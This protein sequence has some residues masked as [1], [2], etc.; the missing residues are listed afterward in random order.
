MLMCNFTLYAFNWLYY[1]FYQIIIIIIINLTPLMKHRYSILRESAT[2]FTLFIPCTV[3]QLSL[4]IPCTAIQLSLFIPCTVIQLSLF[5]PCTVI[6][7]SLFIPCTVIQISQLKPTKC[8]LIHVHIFTMVLPP[9][10]SQGLQ[11]ME[12]SWSH[13]DT[14]YSV[15][16]IWTSD[17]P[18]TETSTWLHA[19]LTTDRHPCPRKD[20]N[21][22]SQQ[23]SGRRPMPQ[24]ARSNASEFSWF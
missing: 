2:V 21:P 23:A 9:L 15:G 20:S 14:P 4:F 19:T 8:T 24:T 10:V 16:L 12:D 11:I 17:Q 3:I 5:I 22:Q 6:Q 1:T 13:S 7:L 18:D